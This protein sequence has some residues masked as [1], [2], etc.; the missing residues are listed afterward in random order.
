M[1]GHY[2][3][4]QAAERQKIDWDEP[5]EYPQRARTV[6][7]FDPPQGL[8]EMALDGTFI[9]SWVLE[10]LVVL[11]RTLRRLLSRD[12]T[13]VVAVAFE[14]QCMRAQGHNIFRKAADRKAMHAEGV[15]LAAAGTF[16]IHLVPIGAKAVKNGITGDP[17]A[18]KGTVKKAVLEKLGITVKSYH[19]AD[20]IAV[21]HELLR[22]LRKGAK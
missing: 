13:E 11:D 4:A 8:A 22:R 3:G 9:A 6:L 2:L 14:E 18:S 10:D 5:R 19:E 20:A 16:G 17:S 7:A 1:P 15:I 12:D 21:G